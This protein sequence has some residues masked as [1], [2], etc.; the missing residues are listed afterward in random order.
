M[1]RKLVL[2]TA[3]VVAISA[4]MLADHGGGPSVAGTPIPNV[5]DTWQGTWTHEIGS[6]QITLRLAQEGAKV[7]GK[8]SVVGVVPV[9]GPEQEISL[10]EEIHGGQL[11]DSTLMFHVWAEHAPVD[12]VNFTLTVSGEGMVG[13]VCGYTCGKVRVQKSFM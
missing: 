5:A 11:E 2:W 9:F 13:T 3:V 7:T 10:G 1:R 8:Q 12:R 6:G 4:V